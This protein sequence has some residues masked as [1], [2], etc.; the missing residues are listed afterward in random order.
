MLGLD[1]DGVSEPRFRPPLCA[2][3][4]SST[5]LLPGVNTSVNMAFYGYVNNSSMPFCCEITSPGIY[6]LYDLNSLNVLIDNRGVIYLPFLPFFFAES[7]AGPK[8]SL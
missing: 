2:G 4:C 6:A 3:D 8:M 5:F 1:D 7:S